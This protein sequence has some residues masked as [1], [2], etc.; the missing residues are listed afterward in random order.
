MIDLN[1]LKESMEDAMKYPTFGEVH[2]IMDHLL[3][4][5]GPICKIG[6]VCLVGEAKT[7]FE[8]IA[9]KGNNVQLMPLRFESDVCIKDR[10]YLETAPLRL[11]TLNHLLGRVVN[12]LGEFI[13]DDFSY[14]YYPKEEIDTKKKPISAMSRQR[15]TNIMPT[16]IKAIDGLLTIG[17]GQRIGIFAGTGVGKS[18]L[19]GMIA[20]NAVADINIIALIGERGREVK[21]F[22]EE[23]LGEEG[24][25]KSIIVVST[26]DEARL[27]NIKA[28][29]LAT[30]IAE[31]YRDEGKR[32]LL[33]MDSITRFAMAK[34]EIDL[35]TGQ[36]APGGKTPSMETSMQRL[37]ERAGMGRV[38]SITGIYTVLVE[39][40]DMQGPIPDMARGILDGHIVLD[41]RIAD[42]NHFPAINVLA[43]KSRVMD[44]IVL[45]D[46][47]K[48]SR[49]LGK[50]LSIY[51]DN[52]DS[53]TFGAYERG[54]DKEV[55]FAKMVYP[56]I[57]AFLQQGKE[58]NVAIDE[59][60]LALKELF[61]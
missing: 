32:V 14:N 17:E 38:G 51:K 46:H 52:E 16:G 9:L 54:R 57:Q 28:A 22:I 44:L 18:T 7:P 31:K 1:R 37:L 13:D 56:Q 40:D 12:G 59:T 60:I 34:R 3:I 21:E 20:K 43:S 6:D 45:P 29:E 61:Q 5:K 48:A 26:S 41:R 30:S 11:P 42:M 36:L 49:D 55:D 24:L 4:S 25:K 27:M 2:T 33:M 23:N 35:A 58:D 19:L 53:F 10:V 39:G 15:I 47:L 50:Y 8:V